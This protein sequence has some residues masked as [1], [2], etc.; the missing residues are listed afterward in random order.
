ML[1]ALAVANYRSLRSLVIPLGRLNVITGPNGSGKSNLYR[2]L[3][4]L[5]EM[6]QGGAVASLAREGGL[7][8]TLWAGPETLSRAVRSGRQPVQGT[9]RRE[10]VHLRLG[11][12]SEDF[13]YAIDLG[14][15]VPVPRTAFSRDPE[16]K[17][18]S[19]WA[20]PVLRPSALLVE[21]RGPLVRARDDSGRLEV[22]ANHLAPWESMFSQIAD[23]RACPEVLTLRERIRSWRFYDHFRCD[24][25]SPARQPQIG[26]RTPALAHDGRDLPAA[27]QTIREIGDA[28]ALDA[29][30]GDAFPGA[31]LEI[32]ESDGRFSLAWRQHGLL[33]ALSAAELSDGTLRYL[34]WV[35]AL[36]TPR[37]PALLV[38]NEPETSL[39]PDLLP[40]LARL[41]AHAAQQTQVW[42][43]SHAT[44]FVAALDRATECRQIVL[45]KSMGETLVQGMGPLEGPPWA[46]PAR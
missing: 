1:E 33:R 27:L 15:P 23:A 18:E 44:R 37:P 9:R 2:A 20:G 4:L 25:D 36:L 11:F 21:R 43:V 16:I 5:A 29:A 8:S 32:E 38:L 45:E 14:L 13:G 40:A 26:T 3:R 35:A 42:V 22:I 6:A 34:L 46:W 24:A 7:Q 10:P 39:H 31:T 28:D 17:G 19:I 41:V 30:I 12:A